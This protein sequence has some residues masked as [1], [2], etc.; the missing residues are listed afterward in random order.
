MPEPLLDAHDLAARLHTTTLE[1]RRALDGIQPH[2]RADGIRWFHPS[3]LPE[4]RAAILR[5]RRENPGPRL[6]P[7]PPLRS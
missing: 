6:G 3:Q 5:Y 4:I 1:I 7:K 2:S